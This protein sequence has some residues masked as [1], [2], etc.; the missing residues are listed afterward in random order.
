MKIV[1]DCERMKH[2][3]TGLYEY[4]NQLGL[5][6][7]SDMTLND[8]LC[9][10]IPS[11]SFKNHFGIG[12]QCS[13]LNLNLCHKLFNA[14]V[15]NMD[16]WHTTYQS[17]SYMGN[18]KNVK[19]VLTV[20]DLNYLYEKTDPAKIK[21]Y[22]RIV[23][24]NIDK[25][26][27]IIAIS[28]F[29]KK[30]ILEHLDTQG[31]PISVIYNGCNVLNFP[32]FDSPKYKPQKPFLFSIGTVIPKKNFHV[33]PCLLKDNDYE[34]IIAG[35]G[36]P[37]YEAKIMEEARKHGVA[38]RVKVI[39]AI[40]AEEKYWYFKNCKAFLFPSLAEGFG[41]PAIE[42]MSFGKPAFLSTY[43]SLPEIGGDKAYYF[44]SFEPEAMQQAFKKGM[45][46]YKDEKSGELIK[47]HA[48]RYNWEDAAKAYWKVYESLM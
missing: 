28:E 30:D 41:I 33:L 10:Y 43:T 20:H 7:Q 34:L 32:L 27:H 1:F 29:A 5:A 12:K 24:N 17:S 21:K 23:Q 18:Y 26:D 11:S 48:T 14:K 44:D 38:N 45:Q 40:S 47:V 22:Q 13:Y 25:A 9:Y 42:A 4:C 36:T 35:K 6:L 15:P 16:I 31:K 2:P 39:G 19:Q 8:E 46:H 3:F 37:D